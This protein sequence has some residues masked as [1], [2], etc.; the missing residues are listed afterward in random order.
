MTTKNNHFFV[1]SKLVVSAISDQNGKYS[2]FNFNKNS[3]FYKTF[4]FQSDCKK[5]RNKHFASKNYEKKGKLREWQKNDCGSEFLNYDGN[6]VEKRWKNES[7]STSATNNSILSIHISAYENSNEAL[8]DSLNKSFQKSLLI[9]K[10]KQIIP[11]STFVSQNPFEFQR[12]QNDKASEPEVAKFKAS[13]RLNSN[14]SDTDNNQTVKVDVSWAEISKLDSELQE[15]ADRLEIKKSKE[16]SI[17]VFGSKDRV[18]IRLATNGN[19][20]ETVQ[21]SRP[22]SPIKLEKTQDETSDK[23]KIDETAEVG[24]Q[25]ESMSEN[26]MKNELVSSFAFAPY[27]L[28]LGKQVKCIQVN[29]VKVSD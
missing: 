19:A 8:S 27:S 24:T 11:A 18:N 28:K 23:K 7:F 9:Q 1:E 21:T 6:E 13:Q 2:N 3:Q 5:Y 26:N 16:L 29:F 25:T 20:H 10:Q 4:D 12:Q 22:T 14:K 15:A 17:I